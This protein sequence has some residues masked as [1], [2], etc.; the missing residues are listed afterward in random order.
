ME[1]KKKCSYFENEYINECPYCDKGIRADFLFTNAERFDGIYY[2][3][4]LCK[5]PIC[6]RI[7]WASYNFDGILDPLGYPIGSAKVTYH[8]P[9][10]A[11]TKFSIEISNLSPKF[12]AQ[13]NQAEKAEQLGLDDVCGLAYRRAFEY[14]IKDFT[15]KLSPQQETEILSDNM[16]SNVINNRLPEKYGINEIK[17]ISKRVWWLGSDYAHCQKHY[18]DKDISDLKEC[19][20]ITQHYITLYLK[21]NYQIDTIPKQEW[22]YSSRKS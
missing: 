16:L 1:E 13:Y 18:V 5:C 9:K 19:I 2:I 14:L 11:I 7:F 6:N 4:S 15:I 22:N 20:D 12:V 8:P 10:Q 3:D 17:E 21:Y